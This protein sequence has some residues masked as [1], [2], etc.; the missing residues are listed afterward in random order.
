MSNLQLLNTLISYRT[1]FSTALAVGNGSELG[2]SGK[3][4]YKEPEAVGFLFPGRQSS[5]RPRSFS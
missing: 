5:G 4:K 3:L 2:E 1:P